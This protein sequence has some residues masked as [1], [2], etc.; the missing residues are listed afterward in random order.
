MPVWQ[1]LDKA[2]RLISAVAK[3]RAICSNMNGERYQVTLEKD[4]A[5]V[6]NAQLER[7]VSFS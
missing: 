3:Q 2:N 7:R 6:N 1:H 5:R 4:I